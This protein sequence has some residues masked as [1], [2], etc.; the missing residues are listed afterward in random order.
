MRKRWPLIGLLILAGCTIVVL[1]FPSIIVKALGRFRHE[2]FFDGQPTSYW[3]R[4][5]KKET[6][7]GRGPPAGDIGKI[8]KEG[9]AAAVPVLSELVDSS[10]PN[11]R[12]EGLA[13]LSLMGPAARAAEPVL[14]KAIKTEQHQGRFRLAGVTLAKVAPTSATNGLASVA[15]DQVDDGSRRSWALSVLLDL[16]PDCQ[17]ALP[18]LNQLVQNPEENVLLRV[19]AARVLWRLKQ[20]AQSLIPMLCQVAS[21]EESRAGVQ[22]LEAL[23]EMGPA[24]EPA[25]PK[26]IQ[27]LERPKL[28]L[29]G[30]AFG[31]AHCLAVA[32]CLGKIGAGANA[33]VPAVMKCLQSGNF[34]LRIEVALALARIGPAAKRALAIRDALW[35]SSITLLATGRLGYLAGPALVEVSRKCWVPTD[36]H[37]RPAIRDAI[38]KIDPIAVKPPPGR[39][40][41][42]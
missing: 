19:A 16:A 26:L 33:A 35:G 15:G 12:S 18:V 27:L 1:A 7:L 23:E 4:G 13:A 22:A 36:M 11:L 42:F 17:G 32:S 8:L 21:A 6:F 39:S 37:S 25:V 20:P 30:Q 29:V 41:G 34:N 9:G 28:P 40:G 31:P 14:I 10:D 38:G 24:A 3:I 5:L 2:A